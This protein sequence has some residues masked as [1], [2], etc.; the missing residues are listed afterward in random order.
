MKKFL[1]VV[2]CLALT[3]ITSYV[4][5]QNVEDVLKQRKEMLKQTKTEMS[6]KADK[7]AR[8]AAKQLAKEG[9]KVM[10]G[11]LPMDKQLDRS[12]RMQ[13]E[14]GQDGFNSFIFGD[15][16]S[17]G[18]NYDGAKA[19]ALALAKQNLAGNIQTSVTAII[20]NKVD[21]AQL[22]ANEAATVTKSL[23]TGKEFISQKLGRTIPVTEMYRDLPNGNK[24]VR[25]MLAY[26]QQMAVEVAKQAIREDMEKEGDKLGDQ[27]DKMLGLK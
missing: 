7:S 15:A 19:S 8:K 16:S 1:L 27:L 2:I 6:A 11:Q 26:S 13:Y 23:S 18:E 10:P 20:K 25:V 12:Y 4:S 5:S 21:N 9:W 14:I 17:I 3:G 22:K 24:E